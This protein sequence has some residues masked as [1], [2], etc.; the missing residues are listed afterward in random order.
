[1]TMKTAGTVAALLVGLAGDPALAQE[2]QEAADM[3]LEDAGFVM[4]PATTPAGL[5]S[6]RKLP[7]RRFVSRGQGDKRYFLYADPDT[8][9]CVF[10]GDAK[11]MQSFRDMRAK[12]PQFRNVPGTGGGVEDVMVTDMDRDFTDFEPNEIFRAPF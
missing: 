7:P 8:C 6:L 9:K 1:M 12:L 5:A 4:R 2:R 11:A 10:V 3:K